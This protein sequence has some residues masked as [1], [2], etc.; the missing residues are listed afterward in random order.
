MGNSFSHDMR[1]MAYGLSRG[2]SDWQDAYVMEVATRKVLPDRL[3]WLKFSSYEWKGDG[4][5]Y[6]RFD[7]PAD[8]TRALTATNGMNSSTS[9][10]RSRGSAGMPS[11]C[12]M[13]PWEN[14]RSGPS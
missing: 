13:P 2:G 3:R 11:A 12:A 10:I 5:Y 8:T 1:S 4:F 7:A 6:S 9:A 14:N